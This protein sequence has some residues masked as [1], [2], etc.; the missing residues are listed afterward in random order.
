MILVP[1]QD[2]AFFFRGPLTA[3]KKSKMDFYDLR[4]YMDQSIPARKFPTAKIGAIAQ[5]LT[6]VPDWM[7]MTPEALNVALESLSIRIEGPISPELSL[8]ERGIMMTHTRD[9]IRIQH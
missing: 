4:D 8:Q 7:I 1:K 2:Q 9:N 6:D 5:I 3:M